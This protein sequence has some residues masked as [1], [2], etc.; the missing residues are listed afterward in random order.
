MLPRRVSP[1]TILFAPAVVLSDAESDTT[2]ADTLS[3]QLIPIHNMLTN[4]NIQQILFIFCSP[5]WVFNN[6]G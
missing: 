6:S 2:A 1:I 5:L 4:A 3:G